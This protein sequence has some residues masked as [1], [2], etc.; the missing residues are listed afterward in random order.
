[1][2]KGLIVYFSRKGNNYVNGSIKNLTV[3]N[4][5]VAANM[6]QEITGA[7][8]F[9]IEP[10]IEYNA[11]YNVCTEE[12]QRDKRSNARPEFKNVPSDITEYDT[13]YLGYPNYW[14]TMP[15]HVWTFLEKYDFTG[16]TIKPFCT[17]E[18]S[19]LGS[20]ERDIQKL[21]PGAKVEKGIA[22]HGAEVNRAKSSIEKWL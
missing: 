4:T 21:C 18:G 10:V 1:M 2:A 9:K 12:A 8:I 14:G 7:D 5:E 11:D 17:H 6:I 20:S 13:I 19:G 16:R 22:I 3:G 15:M